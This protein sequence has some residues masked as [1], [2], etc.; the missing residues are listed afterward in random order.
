MKGLS[1]L[2]RTK[3]RCPVRSTYVQVTCMQK[4]SCKVDWERIQLGSRSIVGE[5]LFIVH[6]GNWCCAMTWTVDLFTLGLW[7]LVSSKESERGL[8]VRLI[9][10]LLLS[11]TVC[12][13]QQYRS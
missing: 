6:R 4:T 8:R 2:I 11:R 1:Y 10:S 12:L 13:E 7:V 3:L 5:V 9:H